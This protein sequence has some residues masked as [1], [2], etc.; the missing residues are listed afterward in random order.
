VPKKA[1]ACLL[2]V[3]WLWAC[4]GDDN[5]GGGG[6]ADASSSVDGAP[7]ESDAGE[8]VT[9]TITSYLGLH[10]EPE[11]VPLVAAETGN[12]EWGHLSGSDGVYRFDVTGGRY[13]IVWVCSATDI[14][15][16]HVLQ[17]TTADGTELNVWCHDA[18]QEYG[19]YT[20]NVGGLPAGYT[21]SVTVSGGPLEIDSNPDTVTS[22]YTTAGTWDAVVTTRNSTDNYQRIA[23]RRNVT[24]TANNTTTFNVPLG[25]ASRA[26]EGIFALAHEGER[27][28]DTIT[29]TASL[30][31]IHRT[32]ADLGNDG[33]DSDAYAGVPVAALMAGDYHYLYGYASNGSHTRTVQTWLHAPADVVLDYSIADVNGSVDIA[34]TDPYIR[35]RFEIEAVEGATY[36]E[37]KLNQLGASLT[38][39][40]TIGWLGEASSYSWTIPDFSGLEGWMENWVVESGLESGIFITAGAT[41]RP[42]DDDTLLF[43]DWTTAAMPRAQLDGHTVTRSTLS[44]FFTP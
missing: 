2:F 23:I 20:A 21:G 32:N 10:S 42:F 7:G 12:G 43:S 3:S 1:L 14:F 33:A 37:G 9:I 40:A 31:T 28:G 19:A 15:Q 18:P 27:I 38:W 16:V 13:G 30:A 34:S 8:P 5:G 39:T 24:I 44:G 22:D 26:F 17:A 6:R 41:E 25:T 36:Y 35:P 29:Q 11:T 4:G